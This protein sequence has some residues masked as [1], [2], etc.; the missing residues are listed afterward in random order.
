G[1][2]LGPPAVSGLAA[3]PA[4]DQFLL[5]GPPGARPLVRSWAARGERAPGA[6]GRVVG[7]RGRAEDEHLRARPGD[8]V[9]AVRVVAEVRPGAARQLLPGTGCG[10]VGDVEAPDDS[11]LDADAVNNHLAAGP[12]SQRLRSRLTGRCRRKL[13]PGTGQLPRAEQRRP[14]DARLPGFARVARPRGH[15]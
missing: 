1:E 2:A 15:R 4:P 12:H 14:A 10:Q 8:D 13:A 3:D 7:S 9:A 11:R 5:A 6:G